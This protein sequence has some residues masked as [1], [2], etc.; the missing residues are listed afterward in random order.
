MMSPVTT[1]SAMKVTS[2]ARPSYED[3]TSEVQSLRD[4]LTNLQSELEHV[5]RERDEVRTSQHVEVPS[6]SSLGAEHPGR[7]QT[8][9]QRFLGTVRAEI[10]MADARMSLGPL[11]SIPTMLHFVTPPQINKLTNRAGTQ[12]V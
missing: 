12:P 10:D 2:P 6:R 1:V 5:R 9:V 7:C 4:R 11:Q 8:H 3:L